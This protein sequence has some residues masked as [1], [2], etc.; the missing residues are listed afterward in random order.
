MPIPSELFKHLCLSYCHKYISIA[1]QCVIFLNVGKIIKWM[2]TAHLSMNLNNYISF[3]RFSFLLHKQIILKT[4]KSGLPSWYVMKVFSFQYYQ[5]TIHFFT[6]KLTFYVNTNQIILNVPSQ[7]LIWIYN[8]YS[9][10]WM[11][12]E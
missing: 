9:L 5:P 7:V 8:I 1:A 12:A 11:K 2:Q 10:L 4:V 3:E 6:S